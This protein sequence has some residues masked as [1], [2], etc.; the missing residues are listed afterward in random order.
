ML[1][2]GI[3]SISSPRVCG[4]VPGRAGPGRGSVVSQGGRPDAPPLREGTFSVRLSV[5]GSS[6]IYRFLLF[7]LEDLRG[8]LFSFFFF[9][10]KVTFRCLLRSRGVAQFPEGVLGVG[11]FV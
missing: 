5:Q 9:F 8:V 10:K 3:D 7:L 2:E 11:F 1:D 4:A 6:S